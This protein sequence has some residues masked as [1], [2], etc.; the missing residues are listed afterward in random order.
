MKNSITFLM[1]SLFVF[2]CGKQQTEKN[3]KNNLVDSNKIEHQNLNEIDKLFK[4][5]YPNLALGGLLLK[6]VNGN[7]LKTP[8]KESEYRDNK[9]SI[10]EIRNLSEVIRKNF[11]FNKKSFK[12]D[13]GLY[14]N[15]IISQKNNLS[16][17]LA[18]DIEVTH[19][20]QIKN[21]YL[22]EIISAY[23]QRS[24][25]LAKEISISILNEILNKNPS[26]AT[27]L[28][29]SIDYTSKDRMLNTIKTSSEYITKMDE[30]FK[31]SSL[32]ESEQY[33]ITCSEL[34]AVAIYQEIKNE[35][36]FKR[37]L[38]EGTKVVKDVRELH[39]KGK[40]FLVLTTSL[41]K[42]FIE[43]Q[44][45][46]EKLTSGLN[47][48]SSK[49]NEVF[50][51]SQKEIKQGSNIE[52][53]KILNFLYRTVIQGENTSTVGLSTSILSKKR[54]IDRSIENSIN[55]VEGINNNLTNILTTTSK[56]SQIVGV[57]PSKDLQKIIAKAQMVSETTQTVKNV[58]TGWAAGG[59]MGVISALSVSPI[60]G[61]SQNNSENEKM[62]EISS[63][64]NIVINNQKEIL[65]NQLESM[66]MIKN[67]ALLL[68]Q[69][70]KEEMSALAELRD[71]TL[72]NLETSQLI[73]GRNIKSCEQ[74]INKKMN[75]INDKFIFDSKSVFSQGQLPFLTK[76]LE[77][78]FVNLDGLKAFINSNSAFQTCEN[79]FAEAFSGLSI[80]E[81]PIRNIFNT[82][83]NSLLNSFQNKTYFPIL[84]YLQ[85]HTKDSSLDEIPLHLPVARIYDIGAKENYVD[86]INN[87]PFSNSNHYQLD[88]LIS[89]QSLEKYTASLLMLYPFLDVSASAW[90]KSLK[91]IVTSYLNNT[92]GNQSKGYFYLKN[93]LRITQSAIAQEALLSGEPILKLLYSNHGS[94]ILSEKF[95]NN[96]KNIFPHKST[97]PLLCSLR[98]NKLLLKNYI[99]YVLIK[100]L[101][102]DEMLFEEYSSAIN[103]KNAFKIAYLLGSNVSEER[104][105]FDSS[106]GELKAKLKVFAK[107]EIY[108][109]TLPSA[110][111]LR[112]GKIIYSENMETLID[113]QEHLLNEIFK[114][115]PISEFVESSKILRLM[116]F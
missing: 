14:K 89:V 1:V 18:Q 55:A 77:N 106:K 114:V 29:N 11:I 58:I 33:V 2:G 40:E 82:N 45:N 25:L 104:I 41:K 56:L 60:P 24:Q 6:T 62:T 42:H 35:K 37:I 59:P 100:K 95:C 74:I 113:I 83:N 88:S 66:K 90:E 16:N 7:K 68:D 32:N 93:A 46:I 116:M 111:D 30:L 39:Q 22:N 108:E 107:N 80:E 103:T 101:S 79:A 81:N 91:E 65:N 63:K 43:T 64:L 20:T 51:E 75:S 105:N 86:T 72:V 92:N 34:I 15:S 13:Q 115:A 94:Y 52:S 53:R 21:N 84:E 57:K 49:L 19:Y 38:R 3:N 10:E 110:E 12:E 85:F 70:H 26:F 98:E 112:Q 78:S 54:V 61:L 36:T 50:G 69:Y 67:L 97:Y 47:L 17:N 87:T 102:Q 28:E 31:M 23:D 8:F 4:A 76:K 27:E 9:E 109:L 96:E 44:E 48:A 71:V 99:N 73:L 5:E